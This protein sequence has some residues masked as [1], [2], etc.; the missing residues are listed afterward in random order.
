MAG[1]E[2]SSSPGFLA[3][4]S[5]SLQTEVTGEARKDVL[6]APAVARLLESEGSTA[7]ASST[8]ARTQRGWR[9]SLLSPPDPS[10]T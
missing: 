6:T 7:P 10:T 5:A 1:V 8:K 9:L 4:T 2:G 3:D